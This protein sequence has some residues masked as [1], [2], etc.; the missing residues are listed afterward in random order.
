MDVNLNSVSAMPYI[1][2]L[3]NFGGNEKVLI[4]LVLLV[5]CFYM[6]F[7]SLGNSRDISEMASV[8][9]TENHL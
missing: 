7:A 3:A 1:N 5:I 2:K 8:S 4:V 9:Y 6:L